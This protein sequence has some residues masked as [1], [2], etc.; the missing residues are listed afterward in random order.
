VKPLLTSR[1]LPI[2]A[3]VAM[4]A[5]ASAAHA[6]DATTLADRAGFLVGHALRCGVAEARLKH[7]ATLVGDLI[8]AYALDRDDRKAAQS[9]FTERVVASVSAKMLGEPLPSCATVRTQLARFEQHRQIAHLDTQRDQAAAKD[10][11]GEPAARSAATV[12]NGRGRRGPRVASL[13]VR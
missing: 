11:A 9:A 8:G 5:A 7:S 6:S 4:L 3:A 10:Q 13:L 2:A 12:E 1:L